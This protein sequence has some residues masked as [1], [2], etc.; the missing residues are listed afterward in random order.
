MEADLTDEQALLKAI[1]GVQHAIH[2]ANPLP[3]AQGIKDS[4]MEETAKKGMKT[5]LDGC[6]ANKVKN[7][8][9]TSTVGTILGALQKKSLGE[10]TYTE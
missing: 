5:I 9:I 4:V 6:L 2:V 8:I 10:H 1:E 3:G 7:L